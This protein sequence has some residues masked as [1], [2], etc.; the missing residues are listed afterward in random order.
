[1]L[2]KEKLVRTIESFPD[3]F[4]L[5]ELIEKL[6]LLNKIERGDK[7]SQNNQVISDQELD[8]EMQKWFR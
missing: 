6:I 7:E 3:E 2:T 8:S 4:T 5:E 1:M